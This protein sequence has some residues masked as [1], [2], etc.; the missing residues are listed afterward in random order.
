M[1]RIYVQ[2]RAGTDDIIIHRGWANDELAE[3]RRLRRAG[4]GAAAIARKLKRTRNSV[5]GALWRAQ[6]PGVRNNQHDQPPRPIPMR[7]SE[8]RHAP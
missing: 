8:Q 7:F 2:N 1:T 6:E 3:A 4:A 5:I